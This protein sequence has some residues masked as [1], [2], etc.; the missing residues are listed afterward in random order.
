MTVKHDAAPHLREGPLWPPRVQVAGVSSIEEALFCATAGVDALGFTLGLPQGLHDG[1]TEEKAR[2]IIRRLPEVALPVLITYLDTATEAAQLAQ[3][4]GVGAVQF[5]GGIPPGELLHFR[6]LC[7]S[8]RTIGC[9]T[10]SGRSAVAKVDQFH[11]PLWDAIIL[12]SLDPTTGR[13]GATGLTHDWSV[14]EDIVRAASLPIILAGGLTPENVAEAIH[15]VHP[16]GVDAHTGLEQP[17]GSR[18]FGKIEAFARSALQAFR[19]ISA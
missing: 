19:E 12:D 14:S 16:H 11:A 1:L 18:D 15:R 7:P 4:L 17:D 13:R 9:I 3:Y 10:V 8:I 2:A 5:H 6:E